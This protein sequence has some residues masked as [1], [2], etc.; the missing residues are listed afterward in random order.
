MAIGGVSAGG[1]LAAIIAQRCLALKIPLKLQIL[2]VP[3]LDLTALTD[4]YSIPPDCEYPSYLENASAPY[5]TVERMQFFYKCLLGPRRPDPPPV[6]HPAILPADI[7]LSPV[8]AASLKGLAPAMI[9]VADV[10]P[11][12]DEGEAYARK[13]S[14][15]GVQV[16]LKRWMGLPHLFSVFDKALP[17]AREYTIARVEALTRA[18]AE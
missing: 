3:V 13:L 10:D 15:D 9:H 11:L 7:E 18:F 12:R 14:H 16:Q 2:T 5:L 4:D 1:H 17:E 8:K 6:A